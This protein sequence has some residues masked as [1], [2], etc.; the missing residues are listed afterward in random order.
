MRTLTPWLSD[1]SYACSFFRLLSSFV[2]CAAAAAAR[3]EWNVVAK[4]A[5]ISNQIQ[6]FRSLHH[7][8]FDR[9]FDIFSNLPL[10]GGKIKSILQTKN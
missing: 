10:S 1:M 9:H 3:S 5:A 8:R 2:G 6:G 7:R 4:H